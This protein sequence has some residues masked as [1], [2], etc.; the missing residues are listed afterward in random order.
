MQSN[1]R[2]ADP[3]YPGSGKLLCYICDR[4]TTE[5]PIS[6]PCPFPRVEN[7]RSPKKQ[8]HWPAKEPHF[9]VVKD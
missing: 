7:P 8:V 5:H 9:V 6:R 3:N 1:K 2:Y 4:P